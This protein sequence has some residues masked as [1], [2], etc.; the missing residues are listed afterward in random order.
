MIK[1]AID[2]AKGGS[3]ENYAEVRY[4]GF[5]PGNSLLI[6][7]CL[8]DNVNRT[9]A[10]VRNAF[11][12]TNGK[13]GVSGSVLHQFNHQAVFTIPGITEDEVLEEFESLERRLQKQNKEL[14]EKNKKLE[15]K[16]KKLE[17]KNKL[18]YIQ[19]K[20]LNR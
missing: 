18:S 15:E 13:L 9:I 1:R 14:E 8:T 4:E 2:K 5:G 6:V 17:E 20:I 16:D 7:E 19:K 11:T 3:E 12:K 10:E